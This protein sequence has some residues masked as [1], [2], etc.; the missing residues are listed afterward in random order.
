[1]II[2][3]NGGHMTWKR[4]RL[5]IATA[6][7]FVNLALFAQIRFETH[8]RLQAVTP[9]GTSAWAGEFPFTIIG[10]LLTDPD[11]MLDSS[12]RF[13]P[14][15]END[16][17]GQWQM[18]IQALPPDRG[19][20]F[21]W[22]GQNYA[23]RRPP[24]DDSF[25]YTDEEWLAEIARVNHDPFTGRK[26]KKGDLVAVTAN[27]SLFYGGK[28]NINEAHRKEPEYDF[29]ISLIIP[30]FGLPEPEVISLSSL[31]TPDDGNPATSEE[32]FD[33]ERKKGGEF[34]QGMRVRINHIKLVTTDG[35]NPDL[36]WGQ[37]LCIVTDGEGRFFRLRHPRYSLG[38]APIDW[39]DAIGILNQESGSGSQGK[40]GYELFVQE[41]IVPSVEPRLDIKSTI[42]ISW[43][44][45]LG[46]WQLM[47]TD[48]VDSGLWYPITNMPV[49]IGDQLKVS[50]NPD[51]AAK[52]F[53]LERIK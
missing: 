31:V 51:E 40:T 7:F 30:D 34:Y 3:Y 53:R 43:P 2:Q 44:K 23:I 6:I 22:M 33:P 48:Q 36:P 15:T 1:M 24:F 16:I 37:R 8:A 47:G 12:P 38:P 25:S 41:I 18:V 45:A 29:Y 10:I 11:E 20:T 17:G 39:F 35:W 21:L 42:T 27:A 32:I 5:I 52:F 9:E 50:L 14:A 26:F 13:R 19:G 4:L 46:N 28:R 49:A